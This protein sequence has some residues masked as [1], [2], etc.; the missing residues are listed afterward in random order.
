MNN[1]RKECWKAIKGFDGRYEVSDKGR[2]RSM[3]Y[4]NTGAIK[5]LRPSKNPS[6]GYMQVSL[7]GT[8]TKKREPRY[9]HRLV[10]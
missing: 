8:S 4:K 5:I 3:N 6:T 2:V 1:N 10:A 9:V 7:Y